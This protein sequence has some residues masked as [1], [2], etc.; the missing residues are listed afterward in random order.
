MLPEWR[1]FEQTRPPAE[2]DVVVH[3]DDG[4]P[5]EHVP[6]LSA[7][8]Y[9]FRVKDVADYCVSGGREIRI[10]L[11]SSAVLREARVFLFGSAWGALC[12]QRGILVLH[13][14]VVLG[15]GQ[16][17]AFCG[18]SG[19]GKSSVG[20]WLAS[21][22]YPLICDDLCH[23]DLGADPPRVFPAPAHV[24]LWRDALDHLGWDADSLERDHARMD[25]FHM[26]AERGAAAFSPSDPTAPVSLGGIYVLGWGD[27]KLARVTGLAA[28]RHVV[29]SATY[30]ADLL[31]PMGQVAA[32][33]ER[34][35]RLLRGVPVVT[36]TRPRDWSAME[37]SMLELIASWAR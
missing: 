13:T 15:G 8:Q 25:K 19:A 33:W 6:V 2:P 29:E 32:H 10:A 7:Q 31:E 9:R 22:G 3:L 26:S 11:R 16:A 4:S 20:A 24:K 37:A 21:R 30:R 18:P 17:M 5:A 27:L 35:A 23:V 14:G 1:V 36:F 12:Y 34:C 28:L